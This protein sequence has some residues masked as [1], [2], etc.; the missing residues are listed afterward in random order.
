MNLL[1]MLFSM[2]DKRSFHYIAFPILKGHV[3]VIFL[4][5][6]ALSFPFFCPKL[7]QT[8]QR[9]QEQHSWHAGII[10][11]KGASKY[12]KMPFYVLESFLTNC[13]MPMIFVLNFSMT[14]WWDSGVPAGWSICFVRNSSA[15]T[16]NSSVISLGESY[17]KINI[18]NSK[19]ALW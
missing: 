10:F 3:K 11:S 18:H 7:E 15:I 14:N 1:E 12:L 16:W 17:K 13:V 4:P 5:V 9:Q 19:A 6:I 8:L 2:T